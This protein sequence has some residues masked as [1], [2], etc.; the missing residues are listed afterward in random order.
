MKRGHSEENKVKNLAFE[1]TKCCA[2]SIKIALCYFT[3]EHLP[4]FT[5]RPLYRRAAVGFTPSQQ[6][7]LHQGKANRCHMTRKNS[8]P[9]TRSE[10][11]S[12]NPHRAAFFMAVLSLYGT[13]G[14]KACG[15]QNYK[16]LR[17]F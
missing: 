8:T 2:D 1:V 17:L 11:G 16:I 3:L 15:E 9:E 10:L 5:K 13:S 14:L 4:H 12:V 6:L 7:R